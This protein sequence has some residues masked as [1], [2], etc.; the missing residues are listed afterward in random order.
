MD[1]H[2]GILQLDQS[3]TLKDPGH[4]LPFPGL[5]T[6]VHSEEALSCTSPQVTGFNWKIWRIPWILPCFTCPQPKIGRFLSWF[7]LKHPEPNLSFFARNLTTS[8]LAWGAGA[9][10]KCM[11]KRLMNRWLMMVESVVRM[12]VT[13]S[14]HSWDLRWTTGCVAVPPLGC[15]QPLLM[16]SL[17]WPSNGL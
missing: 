2:A 17:C 13:R 9:T 8:W 1:R 7:P 11:A 6:V 3:P 5:V 4:T 10:S 16:G 14:L 12:S 15:M